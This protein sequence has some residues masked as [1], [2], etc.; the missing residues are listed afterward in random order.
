MT[1]KLFPTKVDKALLLPSCISQP[2]HLKACN[3]N[4]TST[5]KS[6]KPP[7]DS[8]HHNETNYWQP[9]HHQATTFSC[10]PSPCTSAFCTCWRPEPSW[11]APTPVH[12]L[13]RFS[14]AALLASSRSCCLR[15]MLCSS[16]S[17]SPGSCSWSISARSKQNGHKTHVQSPVLGPLLHKSEQNGHETHAQ[18]PVLGPFLYKASATGT[19]PIISLPSHTKCLLWTDMPMPSAHR[20]SHATA[21]P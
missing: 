4:P 17:P 2:Q 20:V 3:P 9:A 8:R 12:A 16:S 18:P 11:G 10:C 13:T 5:A 6:H 14:S 7:C 15:S 21:E 1:W 19:R